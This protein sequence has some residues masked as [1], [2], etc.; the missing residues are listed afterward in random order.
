MII[1]LFGKNLFFENLI[2][3]KQKHK[4]DRLVGFLQT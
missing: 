1:E 4:I 2:Y 3:L